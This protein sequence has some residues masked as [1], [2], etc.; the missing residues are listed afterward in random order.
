MDNGKLGVAIHGAGWVAYA[1]AASWK[2]NP[3]C[4]IVSVGSRRRES[5]EKLVRQFGLD[6]PVHERF[7]DILRDARVDIV[8]LSGPNQVHTSQ[9]VAAAEAGKHLLME[10]PMCLSM[11]ENRLLRDAVAR[12]GVKSVVSFVA[13][14]HPL[15]QNLKVLLAAGAVGELFYVE[16]NYWHQ[17]GPWWSGFSWGR[18]RQNGGSA[19]LLAGCHAVDA[20]RWLSGD[21]AVEVT[22][23]S[24]N[25]KGLY[26]FDANVAALLR[27]RGGA[28]GYTSTLF[29]AEMPYQFNIDLA[30][31]EGSLRDNRLWSKRLLPGQTGWTTIHTLLLDS[32]EVEHH[33]FDAQ[34][35]H[36][37][38]CIRQN[39]ESHCNI[40]DAYY[41]HELCLAIDRSIAAGGRPVRLPLEDE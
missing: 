9:G 34:I 6:C 25:R 30:G 18:T 28:I 36:F 8:N 21:E 40:A 19:V 29:D 4:K 20:A 33:P 13:R 39:R 11:P 2:R 10:K 38:D 12:N 1:H 22:A 41:T 17:I 35:D 23:F 16:V 3:H 14:W 24:N 37:V 5:A 31:T 15:V 26:E 7:E 27:F 32:G